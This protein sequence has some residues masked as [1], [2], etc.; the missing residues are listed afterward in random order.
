MWEAEE[1]RSGDL[2]SFDAGGVGFWRGLMRVGGA[3]VGGISEAGSTAAACNPWRSLLGAGVGGTVV[4]VGRGDCCSL[5]DITSDTSNLLL[6]DLNSLAPFVVRTVSSPSSRI[7]RSSRAFR[8]VSKPRSTI[9]PRRWISRLNRSISRRKVE[10]SSVTD[11][12][13]L[14]GEPGCRRWDV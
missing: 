5:L 6:I 2:S 3:M 9:P 11:R 13:S 12:V 4:L 7:D 14:G 10:S 1:R 8:R